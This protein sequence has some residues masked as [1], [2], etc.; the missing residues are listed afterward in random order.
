MEGADPSSPGEELELSVL[1][2]PL[3]EQRPLNGALQVLPASADDPSPAQAKKESPWSSCNKNL[4]GKCKLWMVIT[5][6]FLGLIIVI[7]LGLYLS[8]VTYVDED[9]NEII[10]LLSNKTFFIML[11]IPEECITEED[12]PHLLT[13]REEGF[14]LNTDALVGF[15]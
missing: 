3:E 10:E 5:S 9:E 14:K 13:K 6:I 7:I 12:L 11:K 2:E 15:E 8:G 1:H 4:V